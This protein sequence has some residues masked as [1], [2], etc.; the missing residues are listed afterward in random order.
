VS[1]C[2]GW[3]CGFLCAFCLLSACADD[4]AT[5][6]GSD[7]DAGG[8]SAR[9]G[10][11]DFRPFDEALQKAIDDYNASDAGAQL[12]VRGASAAVVHRDLG[13]VHSHG[14]GQ[15]AADRLY[16]IASSSK[17]LSAGVLKR[18][19]DQGKLD[20]NAPISTYLGAAW[21]QHKTQISL[22]QMLS[23]SSGLPS[24]LEIVSF[25]FNPTPEALAQYSAHL[26][27]YTAAGTLSDCGKS[28]YQD[29]KPANNR[30]PDQV[31]RYGGSQ[32][33]LAG[34]VAEAVSGKSWAELIEET[35]VV[36]CEVPSLGY[37]NPF[38]QAGVSLLAYP[39][40]DA[41]RSKLP[42]S[43]NPSLEGGGYVTA[44]DFAKL[45]LMH[46]RGGKCGDQRVLSEA[47]VTAMQKDRV[48]AYGGTPSAGTAAVGAAAATGYGFGWWISAQG[49]SDPGLYGAYPFLDVGRG[50]GVILMLEA[51]GAVGSRIGVVLKPSLDALFD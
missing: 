43:S 26:C 28:I 5:S 50:Y 19:E 51:N 16:L 29:D 41:D 15:F 30:A 3:W 6:D 13:V 39:N 45:L 34:A 40:F 21:G 11:L 32:W 47:A 7:P 49:L 36:P 10:G 35:Y 46:L 23:N 24:L 1:L 18:L 17:I 20:F 2:R 4:D 14:Y 33:Q 25:A 12:P 31:F 42:V 27:Q 37:T 38:N 48:A 9:D 8:V 22:A 44:P